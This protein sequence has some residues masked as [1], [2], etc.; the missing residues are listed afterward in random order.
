MACC[1]AE[2]KFLPPYCLFKGQRKRDE[3]ERGMPPGSR[4]VM[5]GKSAYVN[6]D[7][8][9]GWTRDHFVPRKENGKVLILD[10]RSSH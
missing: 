5:G 2:G 1:N 8:F 10:G 6:V 9:M 7:L 3:F 4:V